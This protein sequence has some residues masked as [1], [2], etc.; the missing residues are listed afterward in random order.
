MRGEEQRRWLQHVGGAAS[1][2]RRPMQTRCSAI[3][4]PLR[5]LDSAHQP[6]AP[7]VPRRGSPAL[8]R[9]RCASWRPARPPNGAA[10]LT[11]GG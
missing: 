4:L 11:D 6:A 8:A 1:W 2:D 5:P 3:A 10:G 7:S 9:R